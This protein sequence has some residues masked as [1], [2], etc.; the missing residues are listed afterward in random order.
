MTIDEFTER[1]CHQTMWESDIRQTHSGFKLQLNVWPNGKERGE[2]THMTVWLGYRLDDADQRPQIPTT[3][4]MTL[5]LEDS[6][7]K[8]DLIKTENFRIEHIGKYRFN[9]I[10]TFKDN[11]LISHERLKK[12]SFIQKDSIVMHITLIEERLLHYSEVSVSAESSLDSYYDSHLERNF[13]QP[14]QP[15]VD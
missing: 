9:Y 13:L 11:K 6:Y 12:Q 3:M 7:G 14:Y 2:G 4:T 8:K 5:K 15:Q 10:G 1:K